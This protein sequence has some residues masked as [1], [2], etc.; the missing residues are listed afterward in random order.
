MNRIARP[1]VV[2]LLIDDLGF[3]DLRSKDLYNGLKRHPPTFPRRR[4]YA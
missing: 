4:I 2:T 1:N 3:D